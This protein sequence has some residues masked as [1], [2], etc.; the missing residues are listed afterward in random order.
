MSN[1]GI[2]FALTKQEVAHL[3]SFPDDKSRLDYLENVIEEKYLEPE[4]PEF[5]V[6]SDKAWDAMHRALTDGQFSWDG[7]EYPLNQVI[8]TGELLY[9]KGDYIVSLKT[10]KAVRDI[11]ATLPAITKAMFRRRYFAIDPSSHRFPVEDEYCDYTWE[12][13]KAVRKFYLRA[14]KAKRLVLFTVDV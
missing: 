1:I 14:A 6:D 11:A 4:K 5:A 9:S 3:R 10:A 2:H 8:L 7:G 12:Y 13:F